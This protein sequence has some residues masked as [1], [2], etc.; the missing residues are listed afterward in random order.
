MNYTDHTPTELIPDLAPKA[1]KP[2][3]LIAALNMRIGVTNPLGQTDEQDTTLP[4]DIGCYR[5]AGNVK[6]YNNAIL[7]SGQNGFERQ[8]FA[9]A[10]LL[11][12]DPPLVVLVF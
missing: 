7:P 4:E 11:T 5:I 12:P 1:V 9:H 8:L 2:N 6:I 3:Q 10:V